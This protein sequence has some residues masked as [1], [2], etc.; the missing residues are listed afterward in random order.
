MKVTETVRDFSQEELESLGDC[1]YSAGFLTF[2]EASH[3]ARAR[4]VYFYERDADGLSAFTVGYVY[5]SPIPLT[6]RLDE[7]L[8]PTASPVGPHLVVNVPLR[9]RSR[10]FGRDAE[11]R[12]RMSEQIVDWAR[13]EGLTAVVYS[14]VLGSDRPTRDALIE[15]GFASAF[16]EGD[17]FLPI[18]GST[19]EEFLASLPPGPRKHFRKDANRLARSGIQIEDVADYDEYAE[20]LA[21]LHAHLMTKYRRGEPEFTPESFQA[22]RRLVGPQR[23]MLARRNDSIVGFAA[24]VL[25]HGVMHMLR[26]GRDPQVEEWTRLYGNLV[27][28]ESVRR[29]AAAGCERVHFGKGSHWAKVQRGCLFEEGHVY[30]RALDPATQQR[31]ADELVHVD[32]RNRALFAE[33][34]RAGA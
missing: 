10:I 6:F 4:T 11:S 23:M 8:G 13:A 20:R 12:A 9:L 27:Y 32:E 16:Y 2:V 18:A 34:C 33:R 7:F 21:E 14:F 19:M 15:S 28:V 25:G 1:L 26:Y 3:G 30:L 17:F 29:A 31:M 5:Q 22:F 24:A